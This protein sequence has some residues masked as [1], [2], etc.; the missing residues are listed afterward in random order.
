MV[1][2]SIDPNVSKM[3]DLFNEQIALPLGFINEPLGPG[4]N[5]GERMRTGIKLATLLAESDWPTMAD[6]AAASCPAIAGTIIAARIAVA[7]AIMRGAPGDYQ[8]AGHAMKA[9]EVAG[10]EALRSVPES[11]TRPGSPNGLPS[12]FEPLGEPLQADYLPTET[13]PVPPSLPIIKVALNDA[14]I[15]WRGKTWANVDRLAAVA[16]Q[17]ILED[18]PL[19]VG[20]TAKINA[21]AKRTLDKLPRELRDHTLSVEGN[22]G[23]IFKP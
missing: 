11:A 21:P 23:Y 7:D 16:L 9:L 3:L 19:P 22:K 2:R 6:R 18:Y 17:F 15:F 12:W 5:R 10:Y 1:N 20:V 14:Q 8:R 4:E 13:P